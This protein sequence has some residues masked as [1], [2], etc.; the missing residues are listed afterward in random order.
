MTLQQASTTVVTSGE[1]SLYQTQATTLTATVSVVGS[2]GAPTGT[3]NFMLGS[4]V[5]GTGTLTLI[6]GTDSSASL[7]LQGAQLVLGANSITAVYAGDSNYAGSTSPAITVTLLQSDEGF[8]TINVGTPA[9]VQTLTY[10]FNSNAQ[11]TAIDILTMGISGLDYKDGGSSTCTVGTPY[12][13]GQNCTVTL[14][15]TPSAPGLRAGSVTLFAQGSNLPL[16]TWY[17]S[18]IGESPAVTIDPGTQTTLGT[19]TNAA[20]YG[21]A[22]DGAGNVYVAD[23]ANGQVVKIA[24]GTQVQSVV[25]SQLSSPTSVALDGAG[26]LYIAQS[27]GVVMVPNEHGTLNAADMM[28]LQIAGLGLAQGIAEDGNGNLYVA[29][30][31]TG[32]VIEVPGGWGTPVTLA[33]GLTNPHG[34][35]VDA[36]GN[37]YGS[38]DNQVSEYPV[39]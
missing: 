1:G 25:A 13:A 2:G 19:I 9:P 10:T 4:T 17:V 18:G 7:Q 11:L 20:T 36:A 35:A 3:V 31:G 8:G 22:V 38:S 5:L 16:N 14:A 24:A 26:N 34:V 15:F 28:M 30:S 37:V 39:G 12:T 6:D 23:K 33:S 27:T 29:D 21:S 32:D